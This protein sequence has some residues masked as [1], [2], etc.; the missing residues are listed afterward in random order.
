MKTSRA[1]TAMLSSENN[2]FK[3]LKTAKYIKSMCIT[4]TIVQGLVE[5]FYLSKPVN[6]N[7]KVA[8]EMY[9]IFSTISKF[10]Y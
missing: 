1:C 9:Y 10:R 8:I 3:S 5:L 2:D 6:I 7:I 4:C